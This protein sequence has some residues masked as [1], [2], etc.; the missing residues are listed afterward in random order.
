MNIPTDPVLPPRTTAQGYSALIVD[1][2]KSNLLMLDAMLKRLG[3]ETMTAENCADALEILKEK[4]PDFIMVDLWMAEV[5]GEELAACVR[6]DPRFDKV[7]IIAATADVNAKN[8]F[9]L[10][11]F[12]DLLLK[13]ISVNQI[14]RFIDKF[15]KPRS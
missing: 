10:K 2:V 8:N 3:F 7:K 6:K 9:D 12:D 13:P 4:V 15:I 5:S 1:D 14:L 11:Y